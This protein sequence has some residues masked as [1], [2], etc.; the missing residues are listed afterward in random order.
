M[1]SNLEELLIGQWQT[2]PRMRGITR[3]IVEMRD[4]LHADISSVRDQL[5]VESAEGV[6]LDWI[7]LRVGLVRPSTTNPT[8]DV[9]FGFDEAGT[10]FDQAP[11]EGITANA[12]VYPLVDN[13][14]RRLVVARAHTLFAA[15]TLPDLRT[16]IQ[17]IDPAATVTDNWDM[18]ISVSTDYQGLIELADSLG[19]LPRP[20]GVGLVY[21]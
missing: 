7:G 6:W 19:C 13:V 5:S 17:I 8:L 1:P 14:F 21:A 12:E 4:Q 18:T 16:A 20:L 11:F 3:I 15:T 9:R 2:A 10:G